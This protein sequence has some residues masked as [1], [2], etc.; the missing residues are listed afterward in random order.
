M[1]TQRPDFF[2]SIL[3]P[4]LCRAPAAAAR[5]MSASLTR[6]VSSSPAS[7]CWLSRGVASARRETLDSP[8]RRRGLLRR[9]CPLWTPRAVAAASCDGCSLFGLPEASPRPLATA[10]DSPR[11]LTTT[12][13]GDA[14]S[15]DF[16][17]GAR[18]DLR[19]VRPRPEVRRRSP[20]APVARVADRRAAAR[21]A[22]RGRDEGVPLGVALGRVRRVVIAAHLVVAAARGLCGSQ[23]TSPAS[24]NRRAIGGEERLSSSGT[25]AETRGRTLDP[26]PSQGR[27]PPALCAA[28]RPVTRV[29]DPGATAPRHRAITS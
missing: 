5:T 25:H 16:R 17:R 3:K 9:L 20:D 29:L 8:R 12:P 14:R 15:F 24:Q 10:V 22:E 18:A 26:L 6:A 27:G 23:R 13:C 7:I 1:S 19:R 28:K 11:P 2:S 21:V 4:C